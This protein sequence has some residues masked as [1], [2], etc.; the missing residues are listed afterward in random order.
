MS[1]T[2][3]LAHTSAA[4]PGLRL[5]LYVAG[6]APNS[7]I[8]ISTL[9]S[10]LGQARVQVDLQIIDVLRHPE[11]G[12]RDGVFLTPM[13]VRIDPLPERRILGSLGDQAK[14]RE[15]LALGGEGEES[16]D[17]PSRST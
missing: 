6:D 4:E 7:R 15:V 8:A 5:R 2:T 16:R 1:T 13:L 17:A 9:R 3:P 14:L 11:Q 12:L 10:V